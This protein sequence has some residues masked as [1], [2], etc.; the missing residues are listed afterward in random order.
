VATAAFVRNTNSPMMRTREKAARP[1]VGKARLP[2]YWRS[3]Q[4]AVSVNSAIGMPIQDADLASPTMS[5]RD[6]R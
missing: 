1:V 4:M 3:P 6:I 2:I 5:S